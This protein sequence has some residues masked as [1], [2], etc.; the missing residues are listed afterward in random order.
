MSEAPAV[1][2]ERDGPLAVLTLNRPARHNALD[3]EMFEALDGILTSLANDP[4]VRAAL[5]ASSSSRAFSTGADLTRLRA[6]R[7]DAIAHFAGIG[8]RV[9]DT[10]TNLSFPTIAAVGGIALGGG[11]ELAL[12]CDLIYASERATFGLPEVRHGLIPT[13]GGLAR[14]QTLIGTM[15]ARELVYT[16]RNLDASMALSMGAVLAVLPKDKLIPYARSVAERVGAMPP[17]AL[18][19]GKKALLRSS[20]DRGG[21]L[22]VD[23]VFTNLMRVY[24]FR[25]RKTP[26]FGFI[27]PKI[28]RE[29]D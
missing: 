28:E 18:R 5:L 2:L 23:A 17:A 29:S 3:I 14:L 21:K 15:H 22:D 24:G 7:S 16:A 11:W 25:H 26:A 20:P 12:A 9:I 19:M 27:P 8:I 10:L 13:F 4:T 1:L 6:M